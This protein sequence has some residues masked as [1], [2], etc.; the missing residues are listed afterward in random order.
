MPRNARPAS[1]ETNRSAPASRLRPWRAKWCASATV[2]LELISTTVFTV[3]S[4]TSRC[5][6]A[7]W[8][9]SGYRNRYSVYPQ[10]NPAKSSTSV[11]RNSHIP[12]R[13]ACRWVSMARKWWASLASTDHLR[14]DAE[15]RGVLL[16][17]VRRAGDLHLA[18]EVLRHRRRRRRPLEPA[19]APRVVSRL[20]AE[21]ERQHQV[22]EDDE[23]AEEQQRRPRRRRHVQRLELL[24]VRVIPPRHPGV[25]Q[26]ELRDEGGVEPED[27][28]RRRHQ[29]PPLVVRPPEHLREPVVEAGEERHHHRPHHDEVEVRHHDVGV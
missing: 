2:R 6:L 5:P 23:E 25:P 20:A 4:P 11:A 1:T 8:K 27:D 22:D 26:Q 10:N 9:V 24:L 28:Q 18:G 3:P 29:P 12:R 13:S 14:G 21:A 16:V 17:V 7:R 15:R 19:R